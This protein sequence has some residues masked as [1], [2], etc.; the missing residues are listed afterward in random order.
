M[1]ITRESIIDTIQRMPDP[2][3]GELYE[4][5]KNFEAI[6][7]RVESKPSLMAKLRN[8]NISAPNDFSQTADLYIAGDNRPK[9]Y[10]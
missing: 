2:Y 4:I 6:K 3:L 9:T 5:I 10:H 8:I 1:M 7:K